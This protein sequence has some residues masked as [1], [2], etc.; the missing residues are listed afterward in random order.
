MNEAFK[1]YLKKPSLVKRVERIEEKLQTLEE[2]S[3]R[4][5]ILAV[6]NIPAIAESI[7]VFALIRFLST[8]LSDFTDKSL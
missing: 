7:N 2:S 4:Y 5:R 3:Y 6:R 8:V 1:E